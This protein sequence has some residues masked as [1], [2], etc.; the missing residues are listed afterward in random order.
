MI[1]PEQRRVFKKKVVIED[2]AFVGHYC[3]IMPGVTIGEGAVV[4]PNSLVVR[5]VAPWTVV[6]GSPALAFSKRKRVKFAPPDAIL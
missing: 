5:D 4:A 3:T 6:K 2:D 1:P